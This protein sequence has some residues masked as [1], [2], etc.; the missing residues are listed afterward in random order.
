VRDL[1]E[2]APVA[3]LLSDGRVVAATIVVLT[4]AAHVEPGSSLVMGAATR[5]GS[6]TTWPLPFD[7]F[8]VR[9]ACVGTGALLFSLASYR[10][11][12]VRRDAVALAQLSAR[13]SRAPRLSPAVSDAVGEV[14]RMFDA[15]HAILFVEESATSARFLWHADHDATGALRFSHRQLSAEEAQPWQA[16]VD[17]N[18]S[19]YEVRRRWRTDL[20]RGAALDLR[21][22]VVRGWYPRQAELADA[23]SWTVLLCAVIDFAGFW[24]GQLYL[25][26]PARRPGGEQ[27]LRFLQEVTQQVAPGVVNLVLLRRLRTRAEMMERARLS[28]E[29]HDGVVQTLSGLEMRLEALRLTTEDAVPDV[30]RNVA[31]IRDLLRTESVNLRELM[32]R[33]HPSGVD[34]RRLPAELQRLVAAFAR[35]GGIDARLVWRAEGLELVPH[36]CREVLRIVQEALVNV[37]RHSGATSVR[38]TVEADR[39]GW[40]LRVDDNGR[41]LGFTGYLTHHQ[42]TAHAK[43]PRVIRERTGELGGTLAVR[44]SP[45]GTSLEMRFPH[46]AA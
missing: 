43:G 4:T 16:T 34:A 3:R 29:L 36:R 45:A 41:G 6:L 5:L 32:H 2:R 1:N 23:P 38:V 11:H 33:L 19:V 42:L 25:L 44:S 28:R 8:L 15:K 46:A 18:A 37:R 13:M 30:S 7:L 20:A 12:A 26:D 35:D 21:G 24:R 9:L 40:W 39:T 17:R 14:L 10:Y 22:R 27:R 31:E